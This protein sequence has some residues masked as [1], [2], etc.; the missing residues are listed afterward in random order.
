MKL[1]QP[2]IISLLAHACLILVAMLT[3]SK[4]FLKP[5]NQDIEI[6]YR[7]E[8][9]PKLFVS[10]P[11]QKEI[12]KAIEKL[13]DVANKLSRYNQRVK[14]EVAARKSGRTQNQPP[15]LSKQLRNELNRPLTENIPPINHAPP[16]H[17]ARGTRTGDS[18][19][20]EFIPEVKTGGFT[21]LDTDQ[22]VHYT[23][24][25][26]TNEQIR[27][28]WASHIRNFLNNTMQTELNRLAQQMQISQL[29]I[30]LDPNGHFIKALIHQRAQNPDIDQAAVEAFRQASP[31]N[32]PPA[33]MIEDDGFIHLHYAFYIQLRP[34]YLASGSK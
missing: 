34:R 14:E 12:H 3:S 29:E 9:K 10:D 1:Y 27:N 22:F 20:A 32:N 33:E 8:T 2:L 28:R 26:R 6:V 11:N 4:G 23:F 17:V 31:L 16:N 21:A 7:N 15:Q 19:L 13:K 30:I 25:A 24:Y 5:Q 18:S